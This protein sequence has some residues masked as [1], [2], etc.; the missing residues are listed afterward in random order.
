MTQNIYQEAK[1]R[2]TGLGLEFKEEYF[3]NVGVAYEFNGK[4]EVIRAMNE[5]MLQISEHDL[6]GEYHITYSQRYDDD[7]DEYIYR[8]LIE[9][10]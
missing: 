6:E 4:D 3:T 9:E 2:W 10:L 1:K 8:I 7:S 5:V